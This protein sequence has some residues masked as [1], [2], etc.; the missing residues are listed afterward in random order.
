MY[1]NNKMYNLQ[2]GFFLFCLFFIIPKDKKQTFPYFVIFF[3]CFCVYIPR[4]VMQNRKFPSTVL[5]IKSIPGQVFFCNKCCLHLLWYEAHQW[6]CWCSKMASCSDV[7]YLSRDNTSCKF[8]VGIGQLAGTDI[9]WL[10]R[11]AVWTGA[12]SSTS[13]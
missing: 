12:R 8:S 4:Y 9:L 11:K 5:D 13:L 3:Q 1:F 6:F 2:R 7:S 10:L